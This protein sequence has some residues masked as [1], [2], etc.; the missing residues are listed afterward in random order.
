MP[1]PKPHRRADGTTAWRV[2]FRIAPGG[3]PVV[4]TFETVQDATRFARLVEKVGG[5]AARA[6]RDAADH[7]GTTTP[8]LR[9]ALRRHLELLAA[10]TTPG[11]TSKYRRIA[12]QTFLTTMGDLPVELITRDTVTRWV[13]TMRTTPLTR[14]AHAGQPPAAKTIRNAHAVLSAALQRYVD[15]GVLDR[16]VARGVKIPSDTVRRDMRIL[17][18]EEVVAL[19]DAMEPYYRPLVL[20]LYGLGLR[21]GEATALTPADLSLGG[22]HPLV[23]VTRAWKE[24]ER[25]AYLGAPKTRRAVRSVTVPASLT[26]V[27]VEQARGRARDALLFSAKRG[28]RLGGSTFHTHAWRPAVAAVGLEPRPRVHDLRHTHA[29]VLI[30]AGVPLPVVQRRLGHESIQTTVDTYGHL[31]PEA[32]A[33]AAE[34][35]DMLLSS[36]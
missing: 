17:T 20:T 7:R 31:A 19:V 16:N 22:R 30:M 25:G 14:G 11:T 4:E 28:G 8:T 32:Y 1:T 18:R 34:A 33:G 29:S 9:E 13:A 3:N 15:D 26:E 21:W 24:G 10:S 36:W 2:R 12:E 5:A 6:A 23:R 35:M 27:L